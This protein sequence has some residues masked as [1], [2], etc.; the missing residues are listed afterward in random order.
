MKWAEYCSYSFPIY[1]LLIIYMQTVSFDFF[2]IL[3]AYYVFQIQKVFLI[4]VSVFCCCCHLFV[5]VWKLFEEKN[6]S[7][8]VT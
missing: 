4:F 3:I 8:D 5:L 1:L 2:F 7:L 6:K